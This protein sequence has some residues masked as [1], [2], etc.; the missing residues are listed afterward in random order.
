MPNIHIGVVPFLILL[1]LC[2]HNGSFR[3]HENR[4]WLCRWRHD[5]RRTKT[6]FSCGC[7]EEVDDLLCELGEATVVPEPQNRNAVRA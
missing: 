5:Q 2:A 3:D 7:T 6:A 4:H 1:F